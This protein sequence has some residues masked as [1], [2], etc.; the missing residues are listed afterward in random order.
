MRQT[1]RIGKS[2]VMIAAISAAACGAAVAQPLDGTTEVA[3][4]F[5]LSGGTALEAEATPLGCFSSSCT[6]LLA[7]KV[8][9]AVDPRIPAIALIASVLVRKRD[10]ACTRDCGGVAR[11]RSSYGLGEIAA[12]KHTVMINGIEVGTYDPTAANAEPVCFTL[13]T[14]N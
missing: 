11:F 9:A 2:L 8:G 6:E 12:A 13:P 7:R 14:Q 4:N 3:M 10:G 5:C 1:A